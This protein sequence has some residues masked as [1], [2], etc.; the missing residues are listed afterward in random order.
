MVKGSIGGRCERGSTQV[1]Q[2][3]SRILQCR[4]VLVVRQR[5]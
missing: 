4:H 5:P 1:V 2:A 3:S